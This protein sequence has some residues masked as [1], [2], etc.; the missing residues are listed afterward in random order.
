MSSP[1]RTPTFLLFLGLNAIDFNKQASRRC[2]KSRSCSSLTLYIASEQITV[3]LTHRS[4]ST[5]RERPQRL[6]LSTVVKQIKKHK[7]AKTKSVRFAAQSP[8]RAVLAAFEEH[9][10]FFVVSICVSPGRP[11]QSTELR[12]LSFSRSLRGN[13]VFYCVV[14]RRSYIHTFILPRARERMSFPLSV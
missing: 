7:R 13:C 2:A 10:L 8:A 5:A 12:V 1:K 11:L 3:H 14:I 9:R 4:K 6:S